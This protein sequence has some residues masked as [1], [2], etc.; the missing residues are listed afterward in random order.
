[1]NLDSGNAPLVL[2]CPAWKRWGLARTTKPASI[3]LH[4]RQDEVIPFFRRGR[5]YREQQLAVQ[6]VD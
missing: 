6:R 1:M 3:I 2:M 5:M 4:W